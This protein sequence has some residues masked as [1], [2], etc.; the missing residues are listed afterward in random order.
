MFSKYL[1][2]LNGKDLSNPEISLIIVC[3]YYFSYEIENC[4]FS[5]SLNCLSKKSKLNAL[6][7]CTQ[8]TNIYVKLKFFPVVNAITNWNLY[9]THFLKSSSVFQVPFTRLQMNLI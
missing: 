3:L 6:S 1:M 7:S 8:C 9:Q 4:H 5:I 2:L